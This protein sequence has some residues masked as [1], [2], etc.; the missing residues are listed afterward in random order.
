MSEQRK[1]AVVLLSGGLDS[2]MVLAIARAQEYDVYGLSFSYGQ[3]HIWELAAAAQ[4]ARVMHVKEHRVVALDLR[5][6][7]GS[8]LTADLEVP[9]GG[10]PRK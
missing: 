6:F 9:K 7:G 8:A 4:I 1:K 10:R 2:T 5:A 3:C